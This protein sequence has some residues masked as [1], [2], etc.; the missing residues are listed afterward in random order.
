[1]ASDRWR[2]ISAL[3]NDALGRPPDQRDQF[4][5]Q[6]C[7]GD[8][9]LLAELESLLA[10]DSESALID[11]PALETASRALAD[12]AQTSLVGRRLGV[13]EITAFLGAGGMGEVYRA[14]DTRLGRD[15]AIKVL[16]DSFARD[17][18]WVTRFHR[19][20]KLLAALNHPNIGAIY[21]MEESDG[22]SALVLELVQGPTLAD[23]SKNRALRLEDVRVIA[24]QIVDALEAA[25]ESGIVHRDLKPANI[26]V[27]P[28]GIVKVLDFGLAKAGIADHVV[29]PI[30]TPPLATATHDGMILGTAAYMSP[31]QARGLPVDKRADI[32]AFG[33]VLYEMC[34]GQLVFPGETASDTLASILARE[35]D[36]AALP[37]A[38]PPAIRRLLRRCLEKDPKHRLRDIGDARFDLDDQS[39]TATPPVPPAPVQQRRLSR[40]VLL[41]SAAFAMLMVIVVGA[42]RLL[43]D[44]SGSR[45]D[46]V[47]GRFELPAGATTEP[48]SFALSADGRQLAF[49]ETEN[50]VAKLRVRALDQISSKTIAGTEGATYPFWSPDSRSLGFFADRKLKRVDL[51]SGDVR[52]LADAP[53]GRGGTW[54]RDDVIVF[55][56]TIAGPLMRIGS[57]GGTPSAVTRLGAGQPTHRWP[58][59]LPDG[60]RF[61]YLAPQAA[62]HS[63]G[64]FIGALDGTAAVPVVEDD[65]A[66]S[67]G[68]A[69]QLKALLVARNGALVAFGFEPDAG[70]LRGA[71]TTIAAAVGFDAQLGRAAFAA[72]ESGVVAYRARL[73]ERRRLILVD[74][75][76]RVQN[77]V[78]A[79]DETALSTP[80]L[81]HNGR[82]L[83]LFRTVEGNTDIFRVQLAG[84]VFSR[85][86]FHPRI[87]LVP[88]W[89]G[90]DDRIFFT[91]NAR[92]TYDLYEKSSTG[93]EEERPLLVSD[94]TKVPNDTSPD[95]SLLLYSTQVPAT[96]VDIWALPL[97]GEPKPFP[98]VETAFDEMAGQLSPDGHWLAYQ[99]NSSGRM[100]VHV[101]AFRGTDQG[102]SA[103]E[104]HWQVSSDGGSQPRW[105]HDGA[106]LFYV[107]ADS[108]MMAVPIRS[109]SDGRTLDPGRPVP[110]FV[111]R[112]A[113]GVNVPLAVGTRAQYAVTHDGRFLLL[114]SLEGSTASPITIVLNW[115][116]ELTR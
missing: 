114:E 64:V 113:T 97:T 73:A 54:N 22:I 1:M 37:P 20:A 80:D 109:T 12:A 98:V 49:V 71:P 61:L 67:Y 92:G 93:L 115:A 56:P 60:R 38:V 36:W 18:S 106:E 62:Q 33:C 31:E 116:S 105:R 47:L 27:T 101:Q 82:R 55:A 44:R 111:T 7:A 25:H 70:I 3:Y 10:A 108:R 21:G 112:L 35:P 74:R 68:A 58:Q 86:T 88:L 8:E 2:K 41:M 77:V 13:Y 14:R 78:A 6:A 110:L 96:G 81:A 50:G 29:G 57:T 52:T 79:S 39:L 94:A 32:W 40:Q 66:G 89:S 19:E 99:S 95:G 104:G 34:T 75:A 9:S 103:P 59:F 5:R 102:T 107:A 42:A 48:L 23:R 65:V 51:F 30:Q 45:S 76:G 15:V 100:E 17:P 4:L 26:N 11:T 16:P 91:S 83:V 53:N 72:S 69:P 28:A 90:Q 24:R 84:G 87:D 85:L 46:A 43:S 63:E